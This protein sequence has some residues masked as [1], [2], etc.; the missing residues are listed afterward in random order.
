LGLE[1]NIRETEIFW[2]SCDGKKHRGGLFPA[3]IRRPTLGV[4][5]LGGVVSRDKGF[6][7]GLAMKRASRAAE[8]MHLLPRLRNPHSELFLLRSSMGISKLFS[9]L[10]TCQLIHIDKR[11]RKKYP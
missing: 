6:I 10:R 5:L 8:L 4:K 2:P 3:D 1:L 7:E 9:G 11:E